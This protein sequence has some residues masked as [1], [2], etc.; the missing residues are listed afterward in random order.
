MNQ[1]LFRVVFAVTLS[2]LFSSFSFAKGTFYPTDIVINN[3]SSYSCSVDVPTINVFRQYIPAYRLGNHFYGMDYSYTKRVNIWDYRGNLIFASD[4][5]N[6]QT[7]NVTNALVNVYQLKN[8]I[9]K[10]A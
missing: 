10:A 1:K 7:I 9:Q 8:A 5:Y 6:H 4:V 2:L 3:Y